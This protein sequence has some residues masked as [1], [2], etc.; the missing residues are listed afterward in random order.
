[1]NSHSDLVSSIVTI[2]LLTEHVAA[3]IIQFVCDHVTR[4]PRFS[5]LG[6][7]LIPISWE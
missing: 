4:G 7:A 6:T 3:A 2:N 5:R 1:M